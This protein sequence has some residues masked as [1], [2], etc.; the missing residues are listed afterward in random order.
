[1][2]IS[3]AMPTTKANNYQ[4]ARNDMSETDSNEKDSV[5]QKSKS[6]FQ[7]PKDTRH[8]EAQKTGDNRFRPLTAISERLTR[9]GR[10]SDYINRAREIM[11][12]KEI[13]MSGALWEAAKDFGYTGPEE[14]R[15]L[16]EEHNKKELASGSEKVRPD[17]SLFNFE[18]VVANLP[19]KASV[20]EE[21]DWIKSHPAMMRKIR[22]KDKNLEII[23]S[24]DDLLSL[25]GKCPSKSAAIQ[26][27]N[28]VNKPGEF[29]KA[30]LSENKKISEKGGNESAAQ[31]DKGLDEI[32]LLLEDV[33]KS[34]ETEQI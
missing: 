8:L 18:E 20:K 32:R 1:M 22:A 31:R 29:F 23:V 10:Y 26:L 21:I 16:W 15:R 27:Q 34:M 6:R 13:K 33:L 28:F 30:T 9:E 14:E 7:K 19:D 17:G 2:I 5:P 24:V 11:A 3:Q 25:N 12:A 4:N